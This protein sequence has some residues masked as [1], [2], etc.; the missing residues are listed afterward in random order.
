MSENI[1]FNPDQSDFN[2]AAFDR[3]AK[4]RGFTYWLLSH[5]G[6]LLKTTRAVNIILVLISF[7]CLFIAVVV[8][9][10]TFS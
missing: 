3:E 9:L 4:G 2:K 5:S 10:N 7:I 8:L 6:G 1:I